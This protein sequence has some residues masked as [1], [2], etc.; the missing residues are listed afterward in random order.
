MHWPTPQEYNEAIQTPLISFGDSDLKE[1][2]L[3]LTALGIPRAMTGAFAS[4]YKIT[5]GTGHWA[6]RC[7]LS[8]RPD[9]KER[10]RKISD[11]VL[12]DDLEATVPFYYLEEGI[13]VHGSWYPLLKMEWVYGDTL[14]LYI[15]DNYRDRGAM[16]ELLAQFDD[17]AGALD[18]AGI[19]HGDLQHGNIIISRDGLR[20]VDYDALFVPELAG[21]LSLELGHPNYQHPDRNEY[22]YDTIVD[23][24]S[25]WLIHYS[26]LALS[27]DPSLFEQFDGGD[28]CILFRRT[29]LRAPESSRLF[30]TLFEH[31]SDEIAEGAAL[32][33]RMLW[34]RPSEIPELHADRQELDFL[35]TVKPESGEEAEKARKARALYHQP[36]EGGND[37]FLG[38]RFDKDGPVSETV[39]REAPSSRSPSSL[40]KGMSRVKNRAAS[41]VD[42][43]H[44][45]LS[46]Y[47]WFSQRLRKADRLFHQGDYD[48]ASAEYLTLFRRTE[49]G[50]LKEN[51]F[52]LL[53]NM[54]FSFAMQGNLSLAQ[55]YFFLAGK[56]PGIG[57]R[58]EAQAVFLLSVVRY[59]KDEEEE[60]FKTFQGNDY[61][62]EKLTDLL[63]IEGPMGPFVRRPEVFLMLCRFLDR[64]EKESLF[65]RA[66]R[67]ETWLSVAFLYWT[68]KDRTAIELDKRAVRVYI[69]ACNFYFEDGEHRRAWDCFYRAVDICALI[70]AKEHTE[71]APDSKSLSG[72]FSAAGIDLADS[73]M[74]T[75]SL[76]F[77]Q[78]R[79]QLEQVEDSDGLKDLLSRL[80]E[81]DS[82]FISTCLETC[83]SDDSFS[84]RFE[85]VDLMRW[86][87]QN[88]YSKSLVTL[89]SLVLKH[90]S[91][92]SII[93]YFDYLYERDEE[94][95]AG[96]FSLAMLGMRD[97]N[98]VKKLL[99]MAFS[100]G[101]V[102]LA[103]LIACQFI[104][105]AEESEANYL[106]KTLL[107]T[108]A[109]EVVAWVIYSLARKK[110][111]QSVKRVGMYLNQI[112]QM[113]TIMSPFSLIY[114][115]EYFM[116]V[117]SLARQ[118]GTCLASRHEWDTA[119]RS[120][121]REK[122]GVRAYV[123][124]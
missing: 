52:A 61:L 113:T 89:K 92:G 41:M 74:S 36:S 68:I 62:K 77:L 114:A 91:L 69:D 58:K 75:D 30:K 73:S 108:G 3:A 28:D 66:A 32:L 20:L 10:Y 78:M 39:D 67:L 18:G 15:Q 51:R 44:G 83:F 105:N 82:Q 55:N 9:Q 80:E 48:G 38:T 6:L 19:A 45:T 122:Y 56:E 21:M 1:G 118:G 87:H 5:T 31:K 117:T 23:N 112:T 107:D 70:Q 65:D 7:F 79:W 53:I 72:L 88:C 102:S 96:E 59:L 50:K 124:S 2:T 121:L 85:P 13:K 37:V 71:D 11:F 8:N 123:S 103:G 90:G 81:N 16:A 33:M 84:T 43:F 60:A 49:K 120:S 24:F 47:S 46:P 86:A 4:V 95:E 99:L 27:I 40:R 115:D 106:L 94:V 76:L 116:A 25:C 101:Y 111:M 100:C 22:H 97:R 63:S 64:L 34:A 93:E 17:M 57:A 110:D 29:D 98:F 14:D 119:L 12:M 54:G 104:E 35:P 109:A 26:L 42:T